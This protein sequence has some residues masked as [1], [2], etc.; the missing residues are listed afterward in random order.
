MIIAE[1][2]ELDEETAFGHVSFLHFLLHNGKL[3]LHC[4]TKGMLKQYAAYL[5]GG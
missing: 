1:L 2:K 3:S 4:S 5:L